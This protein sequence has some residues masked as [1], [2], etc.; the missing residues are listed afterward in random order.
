MLY[1][2]AFAQN[3]FVKFYVLNQQIRLV[4]YSLS[5]RANL[6]S[7]LLDKQTDWLTGWK[8][9]RFKKWTVRISFTLGAFLCPATAVTRCS[10]TCRCFW[11]LTSQSSRRRSDS[12]HW[13]LP[14]KTSLNSPR[15]ATV[16]TCTVLIPRLRATSFPINRT[17]VRL[18]R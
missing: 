4:Q 17:F 6:F 16:S 11:I 14:T 1:V 3:G 7:D 9:I 2:V 15:S 18:C 5:Y 10:D 12:R 8:L 13:E